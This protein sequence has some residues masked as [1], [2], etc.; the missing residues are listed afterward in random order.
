MKK[1]FLGFTILLS[2]SAC[3]GGWPDDEKK[4]FYE[5]CIEDAKD[6]GMN[7]V[8]AKAVCDCRLDKLMKK[9]PDVK[10]ALENV[11]TIMTDPDLKKCDEEAI[12]P[13]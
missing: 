1:Y 7:D 3:D 8:Q 11:Q 2:L 5:S 9:Y 12:K 13:H 4:M 10:D 6:R